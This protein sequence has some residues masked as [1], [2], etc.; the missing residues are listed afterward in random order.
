MS[1]GVMTVGVMSVGEITL[2]VMTVG[3]MTVG[4][5]RQP[6]NLQIKIRNFILIYVQYNL[7]ENTIQDIDI[8]VKNV[9]FDNKDCIFFNMA[10][11]VYIIDLLR[12]VY[13]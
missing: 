7:N 1:V 2:G 10:L 6:R 3:E 8:N 11:I 12:P 5:M 9:S 4:V 13:L